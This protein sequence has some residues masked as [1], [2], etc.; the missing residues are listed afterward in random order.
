M[1][2]FKFF[3]SFVNL[4]LILTKVIIRKLFF[5]YLKNNLEEK[6]AGLKKLNLNIY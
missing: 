3:K 1:S 5:Y 4:V 6:L 2:A